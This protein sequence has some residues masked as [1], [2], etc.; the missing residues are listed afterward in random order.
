MSKVN[1][2]FAVWYEQLSSLMYG[3]AMCENTLLAKSRMS[4]GHCHN[5]A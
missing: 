1:F 2:I 3:I 4:E 5:A